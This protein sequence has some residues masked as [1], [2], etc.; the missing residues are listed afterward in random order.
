VAKVLAYRVRFWQE[1]Y[2]VPVREKPGSGPLTF[3]RLPAKGHDCGTGW[4]YLQDEAGNPEMALI[5]LGVFTKCLE[6]ASG[7][8]RDLRDGTVYNHR[9]APATLTEIAYEI[10]RMPN[11]LIEKAMDVLAS[12]RVGWIEQYECDRGDGPF[13]EGGPQQRV[14]DQ[15]QQDAREVGK[16]GRRTGGAKCGRQYGEPKPSVPEL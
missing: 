1:R 12:P 16:T 5:A 14:L 7:E 15:E 8:V 4:S 6:M 2:E 9:H 11:G 10:G 3:V 13:G